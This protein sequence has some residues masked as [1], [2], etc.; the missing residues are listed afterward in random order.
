VASS[1]QLSHR[2]VQMNITASDPMPGVVNVY[3]PKDVAFDL[4]KMQ[5]VTAN[6]L[7]R[8]GCPGCHSGRILHFRHL[9]DFVVNPK[10]LDVH[11]LGGEGLR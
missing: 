9:E 10:T 11:E 3:V 4:K 6:I 7:G 5:T 2:E 8:L 1:P